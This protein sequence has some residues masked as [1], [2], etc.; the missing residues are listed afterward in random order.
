MKNAL[1]LHGTDFSKTQNQRNNN[2]FPWFKKELDNLGYQTW[3]PELPEAWEPNLE[4]YWAFLKEFNF[5]RES[6][7]IGHS[8]G[9]AAIFGL[10]NKLPKKNKIKLA[11]SVAGF[12]KDEGWNCEGL[13]KEKLDWFKIKDQSSKFSVIYSDNDPYV[14]EY[15]AKYL[16]EKLKI[17]PLLMKNKKHFNLEAGEEFKQ[18]PELLEIIKEN[19]R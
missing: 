5:N 19:I 9:G 1:I 3:L 18:F 17:E 12:Y 16:S 4:K 6:I 11:L 8:S 13:F 2:W 7:L 14:K 15:H 10:L